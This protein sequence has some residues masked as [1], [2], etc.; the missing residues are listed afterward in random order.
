MP[1]GLE[2]YE[3]VR[4][5]GQGSFGSVFLVRDI[6]DKKMFVLKE[7]NLESMGPKGREDA[8]KEV[9]FMASLNHPAIIS[10]HEFF[11]DVPKEAVWKNPIKKLY[12]V[13]EYADSGDLSKSIA[14][15]ASRREHFSEDQIIDWIVQICL[16]LKH[17]HD[18][19]IIHR[20]I[21]SENVFFDGRQHGEARR[22][23][24]Q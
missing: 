9:S 8:L 24:N 19:K 13:M 15:R 6:Q 5:L 14:Q 20:D 10:Y 4:K 21:K 22:L 18:R 17:M 11:E 1:S 16:A 23:W 3:R 12:I 2:K 7:I